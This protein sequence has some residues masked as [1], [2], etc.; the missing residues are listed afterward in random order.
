MT[1]KRLPA[2]LTVEIRRSRAL[3]IFLGGA[4][5][6]V[7]LSVASA[8]V[9][10][11]LRFCAFVVVVFSAIYQGYH[12]SATSARIC[13]L[14]YRQEGWFLQ[15]GAVEQPA[16]LIS[17]WRLP[18]VVGMTFRTAGTSHLLLLA[19]ACEKQAFRQL[20]L[21]LGFAAVAG[22]EDGVDRLG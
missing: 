22:V 14:R 20:K 6:L 21:I 1:S 12:Y 2:A 15:R 9:S 11:V 5:L 10:P 3:L 16:T 4:H 13:R 7:A 17:C 8:E 19:D 18:W